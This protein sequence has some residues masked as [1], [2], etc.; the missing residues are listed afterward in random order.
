MNILYLL[1]PYLLLSKK[2]FYAKNIVIFVCGLC[3]LPI[4]IGLMI[5][6]MVFYFLSFGY[7]ILCEILKKIMKL[8]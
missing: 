8:L 2:S 6:I 4:T 1:F 3:Y 7:I 5:I